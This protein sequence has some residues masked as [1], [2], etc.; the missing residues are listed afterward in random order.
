M[1]PIRITVNATTLDH[2]KTHYVDARLYKE[3]ITTPNDTFKLIGTLLLLWE[4]IKNLGDDDLR[5]TIN[6]KRRKRDDANSRASTS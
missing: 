6:Q 2:S 1:K 5:K 4:E 3:F